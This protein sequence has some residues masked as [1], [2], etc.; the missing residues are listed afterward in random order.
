[1]GKPVLPAVEAMEALACKAKECYPDLRLD[2]LRQVHFEKFLYIDPE[3]DQLDVLFEF[4]TAEDGSLQATLLTKTKAPKAAFTRTKIHVR[5]T[6][7]PVA[8]PP[9]NQP[10]DILAALEGFCTAVA[11][12]KIYADLVPFGP[13]FRNIATPLLISPDGALAQIETPGKE[14]HTSNGTSL[15]GSGYALD[16]AFHAACVWAQHYQGV[17]AFPVGIERRTIIHPTL[18]EKQYMGRVIP[19]SISDKGLNFDIFLLDQDGMV[20]EVAK[21]VQM[22]DVSGGRLQPPD[23]V[24]HSGRPCPLQNLATV[25]RDMCV[26]ELDAVAGFAPHAM[27]AREI[28]RYETMG[29]RRRR[30]Y[31]AARLALKRLQRRCT[32]NDWNTPAHQIETVRKQSPRPFIDAMTT[33][34]NISCSVSHDR[35]FAIAVTAAQTIGVDVEAVSA[36]ALE[37]RHIFMRPA[38]DERARQSAMDETEAALRVWS[39]KEAAA[40]ALNLDLADAWERVEV[41]AVGRKQSDLIVDGR[42]LTAHHA[43]ADQHLFT[44]LKT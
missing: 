28:N 3:K 10:M 16:A 7:E 42:T 38:E 19:K 36:K 34:K 31:L 9:E 39:I 17:V 30:S 41:T 6:F 43:S 14:F 15:L 24:R 11:P 4:Q 29:P 18:P 33:S 8:A 26:M 25:C 21:G 44:L 2:N 37:S 35:R 27:T 23:W 1:M 12:E 20:C 5:L 13:T 32:N 40:K 22:R